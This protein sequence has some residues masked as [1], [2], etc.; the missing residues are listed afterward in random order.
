MNRYQIRFTPMEPYFFGNERGLNYPGSMSQYQNLYFVRGENTPLQ[1]TLLGALRFMMLQKHGRKPDDFSKLKGED[2]VKKDK[3]A[4]IDSVNEEK[5]IGKN[6]FDPENTQ[7]QGFGVI[8]KL[9]PV[10][11]TDDIGVHYIPAPM[12]HNLADKEKNT[13]DFI[14]SVFKEMK[15]ITNLPPEQHFPD[16]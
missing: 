7:G 16:C 9:S 15:E 14:A 8:K 5:L 4:G 12:D 2:D 1:T 11:L 13:D 3:E 6:S 10:F